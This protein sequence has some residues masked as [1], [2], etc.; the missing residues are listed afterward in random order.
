MAGVQV[1]QELIEELNHPQAERK[2]QPSKAIS[3]IDLSSSG[4]DSDDSSSS[5]DDSGGVLSF[6]GKRSRVSSGA[7]GGL[8]KKKK[9]EKTRKQLDSVLPLG[10]LDPLPPKNVASQLPKLTAISVSMAQPSSA[11]D[12]K[13]NG[14]VTG[15]G[16]ANVEGCKQFWKAGDFEG[17]PGGDWDTSSGG[18]DHVRVHPKFL[19]SNATSHK[20]VLGGNI[21]NLSTKL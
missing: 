10:F 7:E 19:H 18:M 8:V 4:S 9:R 13:A 1:K 11:V 15:N 12:K 3:V 21:P 5:S 14:K 6:N 2:I 20:W 16:S 17:A